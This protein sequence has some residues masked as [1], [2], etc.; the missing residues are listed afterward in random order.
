MTTFL[1]ALASLAYLVHS[2]PTTAWKTSP[3]SVNPASK[4]IMPS[5]VSIESGSII[6]YSLVIDQPSN[7]SMAVYRWNASPDSPASL[8]MQMILFA[9]AIENPIIV[10]LK[11]SIRISFYQPGTVSYHEAW[12][13]KSDL[14]P[15][16]IVNTGTQTGGIYL[17]ANDLFLRR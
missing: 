9:N 4:L 11:D 14:V 1:L 6:V 17:P 16:A 2:F 7:T 13:R 3:F 12:M 5:A 10:V 15:L 8:G